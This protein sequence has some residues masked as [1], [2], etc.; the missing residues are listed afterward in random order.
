MKLSKTNRMKVEPMHEWTLNSEAIRALYTRASTLEHRWPLTKVSETPGRMVEAVLRLVKRL[1][2]A[3]KI[4]V[5][6]AQSPSLLVKLLNSIW[7]RNARRDLAR[8]AAKPK[9]SVRF[10]EQP[11]QSPI[12]R[13]YDELFLHEIFSALVRSGHRKEVAYSYLLASQG[14]T[15]EEISEELEQAVQLRVQPDTVRQWRRRNFPKF[16]A[17]LRKSP[18]LFSMEVRI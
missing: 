15:C 9:A 12:D 1:L 10:L 17:Q 6:E 16:A 8:K 11:V 18:A 7:V 2:D 5:D 3:G 4:S 13:I 14:H